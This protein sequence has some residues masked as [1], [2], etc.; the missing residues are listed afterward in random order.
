MFR[1]VGVMLGTVVVASLITPASA[2]E[3]NSVPTTIVITGHAKI[4][5]DEGCLARVVKGR[6]KK[7]VPTRG[8]MELPVGRYRLQ[9][10]PSSCKVSRKKITIRKGKTIRAKVIDTA[11]AQPEPTV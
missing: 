11:Q 8:R 9:A 5:V 10:R 1:T 6:Y 3:P 4:R 2:V 7:T